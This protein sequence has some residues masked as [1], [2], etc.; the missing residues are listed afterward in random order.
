[1]GETGLAE[2]RLLVIDDEEA[3]REFV[4]VAAERNGFDVRSVG[5]A[6]DFK[7]AYRDFEP[8]DI[9]LDIVMPDVDGNELIQWLAEQGCTAN[10]V[11]VTGFNPQYAKTAQLIASAH[12]MTVHTLLKPFELAALIRCLGG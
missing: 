10:I 3:F 11:V 4:T 5:E 12:G 1:M 6:H 2:K 9:V 7:S 8:T